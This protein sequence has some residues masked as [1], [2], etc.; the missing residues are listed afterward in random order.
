M[1]T[2]LK[3]PRVFTT[4]EKTILFGNLTEKLSLSQDSRAR[5][6]SLCVGLFSSRS[7]HILT[8]PLTIPRH[9][10][11]PHLHNVLSS[12]FYMSVI[13]FLPPSKCLSFSILLKKSFSSPSSSRSPLHLLHGRVEN[14]K[15]KIY[16][17]IILQ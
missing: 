6:S 16:M 9:F 14:W 13:L 4:I 10:K 11:F 15:R 17:E 2:F 7:F 12:L 5:E 1:T 8:M 3:Y